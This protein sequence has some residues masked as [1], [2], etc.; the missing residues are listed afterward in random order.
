[1]SNGVPEV[2]TNWLASQAIV[3]SEDFA[4]LSTTE[5]GVDKVMAM[6]ESTDVVFFSNLMERVAI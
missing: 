5:D 2:F 4:M 6:A 1:M 3:R